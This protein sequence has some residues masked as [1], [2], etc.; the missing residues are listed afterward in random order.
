MDFW[1]RLQEFKGILNGSSRD[2][3][4]VSKNVINAALWHVLLLDEFQ[5]HF[6]WWMYAT[7]LSCFRLNSRQSIQEMLSIRF[8]GRC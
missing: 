3:N 4:V 7:S 8:L 2:P 1:N 6:S 5:S